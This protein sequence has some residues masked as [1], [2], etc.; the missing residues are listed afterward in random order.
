MDGSGRWA[1][2]RRL[3]RTAGHRTG[4]E[5]VR[6]VVRA[7]AGLG[8]DTLTLHAFSSDNWQRSA[9]EVANLL[10][11][12]EDYLRAE[13]A[14]WVAQETRVNV[15]GRRDRLPGWLVNSIETAE[16]ATADG[17]G[18]HLILAIDYS[19]RD[20]ILRAATRFHWAM[21]PVTPSRE[22]AL[23]SEAQP[24]AVILSE[25]PYPTLRGEA[26]NLPSRAAF[27]HLLAESMH[28]EAAV[29]DVDLLIRTGGEQ[30]LSDFLLWE[31]A[32]AELVFTPR[33]WPDFDARDLEA[34]IQEFHSRRRRFGRIPEPVAV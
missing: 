6:R 2:E 3:P 24:E 7:A 26:K 1:L 29:P 23:L 13:L 32:Y 27:V 25:A 30:R 15:I 18:L 19:A 9:E 8:I 4:V 14:G 17:T 10:R 28:P 12:F 22:S 34:A 21:A 16:R 20:A 5:A 33:L 31:C 11:I